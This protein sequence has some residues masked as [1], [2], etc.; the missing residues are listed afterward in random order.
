MGAAADAVAAVGRG[1]EARRAGVPAPQGGNASQLAAQGPEPQRSGHSTAQQ[2]RTSST[3]F[4]SSIDLGPRLTPEQVMTI[5]GDESEMRPASDSAEKP[6]KTTEK[7]APMRAQA[8]CGAG[9]GGGQRG[10]NGEGM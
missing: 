8:S 9:G 1:R 10:G 5:L 4:F 3:I 7:T 2:L 6:A